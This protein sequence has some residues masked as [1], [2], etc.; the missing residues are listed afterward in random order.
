MLLLSLNKLLVVNVVKK[1]D[2]NF[3]KLSSVFLLL[4]FHQQ[5]YKFVV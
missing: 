4:D 1:T 3:F 2:D 5:I